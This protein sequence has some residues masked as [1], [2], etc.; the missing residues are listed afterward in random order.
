MPKKSISL[1]IFFV[2]FFLPLSVLAKPQVVIDMTSEKEIIQILGGR[3]VKKIVPAKEVE[4][5]QALIFTL[6]YS[7]KGDEKATNVVIKNPIPKD[8]I[9]IP[10]SATGDSPMFSIDDGMV[11]KSPSLLTYEITD[12]NGKT[13]KK[14]ASPEQYT[15]IRWTIP[16]LSAGASGQVSFRTKVK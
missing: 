7:N 12:L 15:D 6:N 14:V 4:P 3:E 8:T 10:G 2:C 1:T 11:F 5:G 9:Y 13:I 16:E